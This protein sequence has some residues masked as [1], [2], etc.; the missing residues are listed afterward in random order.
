MDKKSPNPY[1]IKLPLDLTAVLNS[2]TTFS[3]VAMIFGLGALLGLLLLNLLNAKG[4]FAA[5]LFFLGFALP[6]VLLIIDDIYFRPK[7]TPNIRSI[8]NKWFYIPRPKSKTTF[9]QKAWLQNDKHR[10]IIEEPGF[11]ILKSGYHVMFVGTH[12]EWDS[13][14]DMAMNGGL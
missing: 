7:R 4:S 2:L 12:Q 6:W 13:F 3:L 1:L 10:L 5:F 8:Y 11:Y 14:L 9:S